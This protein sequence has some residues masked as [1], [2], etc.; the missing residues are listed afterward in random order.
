MH[1]K[2]GRVTARDEDQLYHKRNALSFQ[3]YQPSD[4]KMDSKISV[5]VISQLDRRCPVPSA[6]I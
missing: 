1:I 5:T 6:I 4:N 2:T 3:A